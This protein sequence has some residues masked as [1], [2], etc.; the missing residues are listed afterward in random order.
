MNLKTEGTSKNSSIRAIKA[1]S[2][3]L[4]KNVIQEIKELI[5]KQKGKSKSCSSKS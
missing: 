2:T 1:R 4:R 3:Q 5:Y